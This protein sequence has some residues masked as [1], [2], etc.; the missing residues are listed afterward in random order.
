MSKQH[1]YRKEEIKTCTT[2][3]AVK[4]EMVQEASDSLAHG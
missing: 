3:I 2:E 4:K 1:Q